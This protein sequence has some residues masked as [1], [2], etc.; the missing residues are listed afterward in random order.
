MPE[1]VL[2]LVTNQHIFLKPKGEIC[3]RLSAGTKVSVVQRKG[4]WMKITCR[5]GKKKGWIQ[6]GLS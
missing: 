5:N 2:I 1:D 6:V 4:Q 3:N